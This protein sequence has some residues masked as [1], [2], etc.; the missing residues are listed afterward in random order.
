MGLLL[1]DQAAAILMSDPSGWRILPGSRMCS[2]NKRRRTR[3]GSSGSTPPLQLSLLISLLLFFT[4]LSSS[5]LSL[6]LPPTPCAVVFQELAVQESRMLIVFPVLLQENGSGP[7]QGQS[8]ICYYHQTV[9][10]YRCDSSNLPPTPLMYLTKE[11]LKAV[12]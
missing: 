10:Q 8:L 9:A 2:E 11:G 4:P 6:P 1:N 3:R 12:Q 5:Y 7:R